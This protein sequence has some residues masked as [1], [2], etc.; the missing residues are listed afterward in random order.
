MLEQD[1]DGGGVVIDGSLVCLVTPFH[2]DGINEQAFTAHLTRLHAHGMTAVSPCGLTGE[3]PTLSTS[4]RDTLIRIAVEV[5]D[6]GVRVVPST[7]TNATNSTIQ[8]TRQARQAG[9]DA[10]LVVVPYY[11][12]PSQEGIWRH[13]EAVAR[14]VDV[15]IVVHH[16]A[17]RTGVPLRPET[18][19]RLATIPSVIGIVDE[20][21]S[22]ERWQ[23]IAERAGPAFPQHG[24][25][26]ADMALAAMVGQG[27]CLPAVA[28]VAPEV[29]GSLLRASRTGATHVALE[30]QAAIN[31]FAR[32]F[33]DID[34]AAA[35]KLLLEQIRPGFGRSVRH[36]L[37][38]A[39]ATADADL[40]M[41]LDV[42]RRRGKALQPSE[43]T[44]PIESC[45]GPLAYQHEHRRS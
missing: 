19:A 5:A 39:P 8:L 35:I 31:R 40:C 13:F 38:A 25:C 36:P 27:G 37:I 14:A 3:G 29:C 21:F 34:D 22:L 18:V 28:N 42:L 15:P 23:A 7:G 43:V 30:M 6:R 32:S 4:E 24:G 12:R 9:A 41:A 45:S 20:E 2:D 33:G 16:A 1:H 11:S 44:N 17:S 26:D 10:V